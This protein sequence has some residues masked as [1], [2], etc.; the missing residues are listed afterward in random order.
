MIAKVFI[1]KEEIGFCDFEII[2]MSMGVI[3]GMFRPNEAYEKY[4]TQIKEL[5]IKNYNANTS[6]YNFKIFTYNQ[7]IIHEGGIIR[8]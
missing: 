1:D 4:D 7:E 3:A 5:T 8:F 2:D 6:N